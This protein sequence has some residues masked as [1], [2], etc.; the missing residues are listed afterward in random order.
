M[1]YGFK[2]RAGPCDRHRAGLDSATSQPKRPPK[3]QGVRPVALTTA[4]SRCPPA[5]A[6]RSLPTSSAT[7]ATSQS[8]RTATLRE[9]VERQFQRRGPTHPVA[10]SWRFGTATVT[11]VPKR[12]S[13]SA[14]RTRTRRP[15]GGTGM[16]VA[17]IALRRSQRQDRSLSA[18]GWR[19]GAS[20]PAGHH[21]PR[22]PTT[23]IIQRT[24]S[25][26]RPTGPCM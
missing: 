11:A 10:T 5:S 15:G 1:K 9:H 26:L 23:G 7:P 25:P 22:M 20:P 2:T 6:P 18:G 8:R 19:P 21:P 4:G 3:P 13:A 17:W 12:S 24:R 16:A 14:R